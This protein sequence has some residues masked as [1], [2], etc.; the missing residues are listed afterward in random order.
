VIT[1]RGRDF[2]KFD[3]VSFESLFKINESEGEKA[4]KW[5]QRKK[6]KKK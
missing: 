4:L 3:G 6:K 2:K 5:A 1:S